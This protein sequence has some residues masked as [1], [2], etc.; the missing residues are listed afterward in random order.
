[1]E[2]V[3]P[4]CRICH[5]TD[6]KKIFTVKEKHFGTQE[7][8][9]YFECPEC[10][11]LQIM[12]IPENIG[13]YYPDAYYSKITIKQHPVKLII[14]KLWFK[15]YF[16]GFNFF[17]KMIS[18]VFG[19][20]SFYEWMNYLKI[21]FNDSILDVGSGTGIFLSELHLAGFKDLTGIDPFINESIHVAD[22]F[23]IIKGDL[24]DIT[25]Q[26]KKY[27]N[28]LFNHSLEHIPEPV[29]I[30][31][32]A[33]KLQNH[34]SHLVI[35]IPVAGSYAWE[36]YGTDWFALDAPRHFHLLSVKAMNLI[37]SEASYK[38]VDIIY[39]SSDIQF[40]GSEL[41]RNNI[42]VT[43]TKLGSK[44]PMKDFQNIVSK[45]KMKEF[46]ILSKKLN[47]E[48]RGDQAIF[49]LKAI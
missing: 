14:K 2:K 35:R 29:E 33:R 9:Q 49:I 44:N 17:G 39:D 4:E 48:Q 5:N 24:S 22:G 40:W 1:M 13:N 25:Q 19:V 45:S 18:L 21:N 43:E 27:K 23:Q 28:I 42:P 10:Q 7:E 36:K 8:F 31:K 6:S 47:Q 30:I 41:F 16:D 12:E 37:A 20:P 38:V 11:T 46:K 34:D 26:S 3:N 32:T 15:H